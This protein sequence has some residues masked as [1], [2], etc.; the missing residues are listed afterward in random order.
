MLV[1]MANRGEK[2]EV[3][4]DFLSL[5]SKIAVGGD[6]RHEIRRLLACWQESYDKPR[7]HIQKQKHHFTNKGLYSQNCG[8]SSSHVQM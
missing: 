3:V 7:Q 1:C 2:V 6:C 4:T 8:C 5:G